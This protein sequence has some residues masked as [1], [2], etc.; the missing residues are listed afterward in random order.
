MSEVLTMQPNTRDT[1]L[2]WLS[3][4]YVVP[5]TLWALWV[6]VAFLFGF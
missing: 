6:T 1:I 4:A 5:V 3:A 2:L